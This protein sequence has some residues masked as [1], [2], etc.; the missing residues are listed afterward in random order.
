MR[1]AVGTNIAFSEGGPATDGGKNMSEVMK[2]WIVILSTALSFL[3]ISL[4]WAASAHSFN[5]L[6]TPFPSS[7]LTRNAASETLEDEGI[8]PSDLPKVLFDE[9]RFQIPGTRPQ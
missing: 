5:V 7:I 4:M 1:G 6:K 8:T 3:I 2:D 9:R